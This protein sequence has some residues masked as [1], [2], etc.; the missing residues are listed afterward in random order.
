MSGR[1]YYFS[2]TG[3]SLTLAREIAKRL[4]AD[5]IPIASALHGKDPI[6][7]ADLVGIVFPVYYA[8]SPNIVRRFADRLIG[9]KYVFGVCTY[10]GAAG[11]SL[12]T[13]GR[14]LRSRGEKL[15]AGFGAHMPQNA[16]HK[17]WERR[18]R[19]H[20]H[21]GR[22]IDRVVRC[23]EARRQGMFYGSIALQVLLMPFRGILRRATVRHL[24]RL[25]HAP[26]GSRLS[27]EAL[28]PKTDS[29]FV[30]GDSCTGCGICA[31]VC[32][33]ENIEIVAG[34]PTWRGRCENCLA[35]VNWCPADAIHGSIAQGGHRY[36][37]PQV[38]LRDISEQRRPA[39]DS[40]LHHR[41]DAR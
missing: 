36:R 27:V 30:V 6:P 16:F 8:D 31:H 9:T 21:A 23:V 19:I 17:P 29:A 11:E 10:G 18:E 41:S 40:S 14:I 28:I 32:P 34:H 22:R 39:G 37:H 35:C 25:S 33:V 1:I 3:N 15:S 7:A 4:D 2:G 12:D 38:T 24:A 5:L 26:E 20:A 13:L